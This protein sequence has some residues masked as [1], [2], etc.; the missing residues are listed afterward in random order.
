MK[1]K[2]FEK[3]K[4][5]GDNI[6]QQKLLSKDILTLEEAS[7]Y[8]VVSK[9]SLYKKTSTNQIP[10]YKPNGKIIYF[11]REDLDQWMLTN[12]QSTVD[13]IK[14]KAANILIKT[15]TKQRHE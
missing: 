4:V 6:E 9:S 3:L 7:K 12:R 14:E 2:I 15:K 1:E 8:L 10:F 13:E 11:K 5:L